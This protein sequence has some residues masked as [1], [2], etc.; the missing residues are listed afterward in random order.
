MV[1]FGGPIAIVPRRAI[2]QKR[3]ASSGRGAA[4]E[5]RAR[6]DS[7]TWDGWREVPVSEY[8]RHR[9]LPGRRP[10][11]S[12]SYRRRSKN[13]GSL[14]SASA[15]EVS[16][17]RSGDR[18][19]QCGRRARQP[20]SSHNLG[21]RTAALAGVSQ[22]ERDSCESN[23]LEDP[24]LARLPLVS[25]KKVGARVRAGNLAI[26]R[27][28]IWQKAMALREQWLQAEPQSAEVAHQRTCRG[29]QGRCAPDGSCRRNA[30]SRSPT[31]RAAPTTTLMEAHPT[32]TWRCAADG[33]QH[34]RCSAMRQRLSGQPKRGGEQTANRHR[35][36]HGSGERCHER[37]LLRTGRR[38]FAYAY[39]ANA[40]LTCHDLGQRPMDDLRRGMPS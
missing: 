11:R 2:A 22:S 8:R 37:D 30:R 6:G 21:A 33:R 5:S 23:R 39:L 16:L 26:V 9:N 28:P 19:R 24:A 15:G 20:G 36:S 14:E 27:S 40:K 18:L 32:G 7:T 13:S 35:A 29:W 10:A 25:M 31:A 38:R 34:D 12:S 4:R 3:P 17:R 1:F